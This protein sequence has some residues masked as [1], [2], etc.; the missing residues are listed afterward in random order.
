MDVKEH[1]RADLGHK[2]SEEEQADI[3]HYSGAID[4]EG[5][6]RL[7]AEFRVNKRS[8]AIL[9]L[10][11]QGGD[12]SVAYRIARLFHRKY[13]RLTVYIPRFCMSAGTL[14]ALGAH[15]LIIHPDAFM[16]PIDPQMRA[17]D[18]LSVWE[19]ALSPYAT[20][21]AL[22][23]AAGDIVERT[24]VNLATK[25]DGAI[26]FRLA[27]ELGATLASGLLSG[28]MSRLSPSAFGE[29]QLAIDETTEYGNRLVKT[30]RNASEET[31]R[32][33]ISDYPK[34]DF[35]IDTTEASELFEDVS[36]PSDLLDMYALS[37][38]LPEGVTI[39]RHGMDAGGPDEENDGCDGELAT[40]NRHAA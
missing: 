34:H 38:D 17:V 7:R 15:D 30:S 6:N 29:R 35:I 33:L 31:V 19:S 14:V 3:Y 27:S 13:E 11:T 23:D 1:S 8:R 5:L 16:G 4:E 40:E 32:H 2:L 37:L 24:A 25:S 28:L 12:I 10:T 18:E 20:L 36:A 26:S 9:I 22:G 21:V 39:I